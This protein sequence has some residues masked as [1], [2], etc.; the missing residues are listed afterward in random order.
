MLV[1]EL[2]VKDSVQK[3]LEGR[4]YKAVEVTGN[5]TQKASATV[6]AKASSKQHASVQ[7]RYNHTDQ[8]ISILE[9]RLALMCFVLL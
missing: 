7:A 3:I 2:T 1:P 4:I 6:A 9:F 8:F 5:A